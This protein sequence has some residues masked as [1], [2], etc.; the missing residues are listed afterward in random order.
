MHGNSAERLFTRFWAGGYVN[1]TVL[2]FLSFKTAC[3]CTNT[4][5]PYVGPNSIQTTRLS[6][7]PT[8]SDSHKKMTSDTNTST[9]SSHSLSDG[10]S[11]LQNV[12]TK[13][14]LLMLNVLPTKL[15]NVDSLVRVSRQMPATMPDGYIPSDS[16]VCSGRGKH[17]WNM[18][19][20]VNF[21][22][23]IHAAV[24]RYR[25]A[26]LR[27]HKTV[28]VVS[29]VAEIRRQGGHFFKERKYGNTGRWCEIGDTAA[30]KKVGHALRV[31]VNDCTASAVKSRSVHLVK[32]ET[33]RAADAARDCDSTM[34]SAETRLTETSPRPSQSVQLVKENTRSAV[35]AARD[36]VSVESTGA[37]LAETSPLPPLSVHLVK[38]ETRC[39]ADAASA[40]DSDET[41]LT[42]TSSLSSLSRSNSLFSFS[43]FTEETALDDCVPTTTL[44]RSPSSGSFDISS[45]MCDTDL[46]PMHWGELLLDDGIYL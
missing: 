36:C 23:L 1:V 38:E 19:G 21:R 13:L 18:A 5:L 43:L 11:S 9:S 35:D 22:R 28:V 40:M 30:C 34:D 4:V 44:S 32:E 27:N 46:L 31:Q 10:T 6:P 33:R 20:T 7:A 37:R 8:R 24:G 14:R 17:N 15:D 25:A 12:Q 45:V 2:L 16:D 41:R 26:L 42:E 29:V 39:A 3:N